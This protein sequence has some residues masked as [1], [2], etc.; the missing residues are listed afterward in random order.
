MRNMEYSN[1]NVIRAKESLD[2]SLERLADYL[3]GVKR[4]SH[5][6]LSEGD[7]NQ[8]LMVTHDLGFFV[9]NVEIECRYIP[10][11]MRNLI[12]LRKSSS[13][14]VLKAEV[15]ILMNEAK[16]KFANLLMYNLINE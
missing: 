5:H 4:L 3:G 6:L 13:D 2:K 15:D 10:S 7:T 16:V 1:H 9:S 12:E 8:W 14:T 11:M